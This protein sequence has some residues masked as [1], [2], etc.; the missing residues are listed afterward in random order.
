MIFDCIPHWLSD[1]TTTEGWDKTP[2]FRMP[3]MPWGLDRNESDQLRDWHPNITEVRETPFRQGRGLSYGGVL[4]L[5]RGMPKSAKQTPFLL[6][7][8]CS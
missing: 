5:L 7:L 3:P 1:K 4:P 8:I 6:H 2:T